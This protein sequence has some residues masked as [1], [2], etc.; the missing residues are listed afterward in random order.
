MGVY[1]RR[2]FGKVSR[3]IGSAGFWRA[4]AVS[5]SKDIKILS[6]WGLRGAKMERVIGPHSAG[7]GLRVDILI[8]RGHRI[9][10]DLSDLNKHFCA[11]Q[12]TV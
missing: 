5:R 4:P 3:I 9:V 1:V 8:G 11:L 7:L 10:F 2:H 6:R 12:E